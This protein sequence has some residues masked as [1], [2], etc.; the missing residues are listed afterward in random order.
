VAPVRHFHPRT[1]DVST[2]TRISGHVLLTKQEE[3]RLSTVLK[4]YVISPLSL[5]ILN[6]IILF[7]W[8]RERML[9]NSK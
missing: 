1:P 2:N 3:R 7:H 8:L 5:Y 9:V 4:N 6:F